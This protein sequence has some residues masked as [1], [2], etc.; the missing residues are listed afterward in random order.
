V[1]VTG[2]S[3][4][5]GSFAVEKL[6]ERETAEIIVPRSAQYDLRNIDA[7]RQLLTDTSL[8]GGSGQWSTWSST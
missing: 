5:L 3:G 1:I 6:P 7:I 8:P 2:D 4:Y